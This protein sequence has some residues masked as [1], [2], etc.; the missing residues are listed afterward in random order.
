MPISISIRAEDPSSTRVERAV[1]AA[2]AVLRAVDERFSTWKPGSE[3]SRYARGEVAA[4][5]AE[6]AEVLALCAEA[7]ARTG[8]SFDPHLPTGF[9]PSGLVKG[10]AAERAAD[11]LRALDG[12]DWLLNAGGD[13]VLAAPSGQPWNVGIED[14][15]DRRR[16]LRVLP[17]TGGA[18]ATS[19]AAARGAHIVDPRTGSAA[20]PLLRSATVCGPSL[21]WADVYA[22]AAY[23]LGRDALGWIARLTGYSA[24]LVDA[25]GALFSV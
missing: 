23:V 6:L 12:A 20:A 19:G 5:S 17:R 10:W 2:Y 25:D 7:Q 24:L 14:P 3:V 18:L 9:D 1:S 4:P 13:V 22:T 16:V 15:A 8:G 21:L 11:E